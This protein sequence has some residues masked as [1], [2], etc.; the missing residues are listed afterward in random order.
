[1]KRRKRDHSV[2]DEPHLSGRPL[3][4]DQS[5]QDVDAQLRREDAV[6]DARQERALHSIYNEPAILPNRD[7]VPIESDWSCHHCGYNLRGL[8]TGQRCPECGQITRYEPPREGEATYAQYLMSGE[9]KTHDPHMLWLFLLVLGWAFLGGTAMSFVIYEKAGPFVFVFAGPLLAEI[10]RMAPIWM[11]VERYWY[12][13]SHPGTL[14][15]MAVLSGLVN[16]AMQLLV[17]W[18]VLYRPM[19]YEQWLFRFA[20]APVLHVAC[21][22][23][24]VRGLQQCRHDAITSQSQPRMGEARRSVIWA[25]VIHAAFNMSVLMLGGHGYGF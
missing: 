19:V 12:R 24:A 16:W 18:G 7:P 17:H 21:A 14:T 13:F 23:I 4:P 25:I 5:E 11:L 8:K 9:G 15:A 22:L 6:K 20:A 3:E 2:D 1:V 10:F